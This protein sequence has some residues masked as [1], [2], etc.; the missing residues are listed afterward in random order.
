MK[1]AALPASSA[2]VLGTTIAKRRISDLV[3]IRMTCNEGALAHYTGD[4]SRA[5]S[6][7]GIHGNVFEAEGLVEM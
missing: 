6:F 1:D 4:S 2:I 3:N 5:V 7:C